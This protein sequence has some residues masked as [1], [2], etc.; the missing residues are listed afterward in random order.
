MTVIVYR[1][2]VMASDSALHD[3]GALRG[4]APK[5]FRGPRGELFGAAGNQGA[6]TRF[7]RW[8]QESKR[9]FD[10]DGFDP[11]VEAGY[12]SAIV[13]WRDKSVSLVDHQGTFFP[14]DAPFHC[15]GSG[16]EIAVGACAMGAT[17][18]QAVEIAIRYE[19]SCGGKIQVLRL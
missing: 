5:I 7:K 11:L 8:F 10:R 17:A 19:C 15:E 12:F 4:Y 1:D 18:E 9:D 6:A 16:R 3:N 14:V 13:V 2:G